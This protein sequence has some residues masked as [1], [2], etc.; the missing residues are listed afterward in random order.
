MFLSA[1]VNGD[2]DILRRALS[3][4]SAD[5]TRDKE[6]VSAL[7]RATQ[8]GSPA[9]VRFLLKAGADVRLLIAVSARSCIW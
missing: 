4:G 2:V 6:G 1:A 5:D 7:L 8:A 9:A 3:E